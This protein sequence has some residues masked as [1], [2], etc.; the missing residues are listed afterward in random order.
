MVL[1]L[2]LPSLFSFFSSFWHTPPPSHC[3]ILHIPFVIYVF[4]H[5]NHFYTFFTLSQVTTI[6][7]FNL[8]KMFCHGIC[9]MLHCEPD[10][11]P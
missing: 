1:G 7:N 2:L 11:T 5:C 10:I 4:N 3:F 9:M 8:V 6:L